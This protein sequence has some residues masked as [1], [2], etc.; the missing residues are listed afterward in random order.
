LWCPGGVTL[1]FGGWG[2]RWRGFCRGAEDAGGRVSQRRRDLLFSVS[3]REGVRA[4]VAG[5]GMACC[6]AERGFC[7][8]GQRIHGCIGL[9]PPLRV[10][11]GVMT[12]RSDVGLSCKRRSSAIAGFSREIIRSIP[13]WRTPWLA[14]SALVARF[15]EM[16]TVRG[17][18]STSSAAISPMW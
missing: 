16:V 6:R 18:L 7:G 4:G 10:L 15:R 13:N 1:A 5:L 8:A 3:R 17:E 11:E 12:G 2:C 14:E 9:W